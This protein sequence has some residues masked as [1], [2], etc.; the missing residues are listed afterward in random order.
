VSLAGV[1]R[2]MRETLLSLAGPVAAI[3]T[4]R[5]PDAVPIE[6]GAPGARGRGKAKEK[7]RGEQPLRIG[8]RLPPEVGVAYEPRRLRLH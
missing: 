4:G 8:E 6:G 1:C 2:P 3:P 7:P 5:R